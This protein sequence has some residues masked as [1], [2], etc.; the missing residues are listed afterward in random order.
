VNA[1]TEADTAPAFRC[2]LV[3]IVGRPN[4]GKSTLLNRLIGHKISITSRKPQTTR[5]NLLGIATGP[6]HQAVFVDTP[7]VQGRHRGALNRFMSR[8]VGSALVS[9]DAVL[10]VI[11]ALRWTPADEH[12][13]GIAASGD[14]P[15]VLVINKVDRVRDRKE[16][17][18]F[19]QSVSAAADFREIVPVSARSGDNISDLEDCIRGLLPEGPALFPLDQLTDRSERFLAADILRE[20]LT[21]KLGAELPYRLTVTIDRFME[22]GTHTRIDATIWVESASQKAIVIGRN[23]AMLKA[24]GT[25]ARRDIEKLIGARVFLGTH[26]RVKRRWSED[27]KALAELGYT[28]QAPSHP[29]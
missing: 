16:L 11:E 29:V 20:K 21:R 12:A 13:L 14:A 6:H 15:L 2:G 22:S 28:E 18:P 25:E 23:G 27:E 26:V 19:L 17:L 9:V 3:A 10:L 5:W 4:V 8:E 1:E 24:A 7:G